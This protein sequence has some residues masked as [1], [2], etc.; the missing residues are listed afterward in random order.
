MKFFFV[1]VELE[2]KEERGTSAQRV[3]PTPRSHAPAL[4]GLFLFPLHSCESRSKQMREEPPVRL[5]D[6][7][8]WGAVIWDRDE[9]CT[10]SA[11]KR[12]NRGTADGV[13]GAG[14][15]DEAW[16]PSGQRQ[17]KGLNPTQKI[18]R[19]EYFASC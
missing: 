16:G 19:K 2:E 12:G 5:L 13:G 14:R 1:F 18:P 17:I 6:L 3:S 10:Y 7:Q 9:G 11:L 15:A 4:W 8:G